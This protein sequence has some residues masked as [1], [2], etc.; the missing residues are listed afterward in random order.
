MEEAFQ[1]TDELLFKLRRESN[2][3]LPFPNLFN[4]EFD[5]CIQAKLIEF[6]RFPFD[7]NRHVSIHHV[8]SQSREKPVKR[9]ERQE[10]RGPFAGTDSEVTSQG[11]FLRVHFS[12][13]SKSTPRSPF[14]FISCQSCL[15][16]SFW[17]RMI[18]GEHIASLA[19]RI[20]N[21]CSPFYGINVLTTD[22]LTAKLGFKR[23]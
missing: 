13:P 21:L 6:L 1:G 18:L 9:A 19:F 8:V 4:Q 23:S 7:S 15:F 14:L 5:P 10:A 2:Y 12:H 22:Q 3:Q 17:V 20:S 16:L 11:P